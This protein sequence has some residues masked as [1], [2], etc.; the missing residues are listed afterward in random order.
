MKA[1]AN[2]GVRIAVIV[3]GLAALAGPA[4]VCAAT[5]APYEDRIIG[6]GALKPDISMGD[7]ESSEGEGLA[8][9]LQIDG[10]VSALHSGSSG[11]DE[12]VVENGIVLRSQW[13][14]VSYGAWAF[15]A[16]GRT[17]GS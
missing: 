17:G 1:C 12:N 4:A 9:S 10:I 7:A 6:G 8:R 5:Q 3:C 14:T 16:A 2:F 15:D 13:E 11:S